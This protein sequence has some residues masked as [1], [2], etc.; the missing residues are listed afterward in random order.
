MARM[1]FKAWHDDN[2]MPHEPKS[3]DVVE[4]P[5]D[6]LFPKLWAPFGDRIYYGT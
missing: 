2:P 6:G 3:H 5:P 4:V 1:Y